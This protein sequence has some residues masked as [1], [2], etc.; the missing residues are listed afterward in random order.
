MTLE[1]RLKALEKKMDCGQPFEFTAEEKRRAIDKIL[2][3]WAEMTP[4]QI[5][6]EVDAL[7]AKVKNGA[8]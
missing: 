1:D 8:E 5:R 2:A 4:E 7:M 3:R 6:A